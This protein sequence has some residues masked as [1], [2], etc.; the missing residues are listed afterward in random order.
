[1]EERF[2][3]EEYGI[4]LCLLDHQLLITVGQKFIML[5]LC[6]KHIMNQ[7]LDL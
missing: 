3:L 4:C 6:N 7:I 5:E 2:S 1:M